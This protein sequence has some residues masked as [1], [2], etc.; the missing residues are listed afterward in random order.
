MTVT[1]ADGVLQFSGPDRWLATAPGGG[2]RTGPVAYNVSVPEGFDRTDLETYIAERR[3]RAG[4]ERAGPA[5]LTGVALEHA[6]TARLDP[7]TVVATAGLSNPAALPMEPDSDASDEEGGAA[8]ADRETGTVNLLV[9]TTR[10][11]D[12]GAQATLLATAVEAKTAT[13]Q[14]VTGF[15]GTTS[16]AVVV[17]STT[18]GEPADFAGSGTPVGAATRACVREAV[19]AS[20]HS[21]YADREVPDSVADADHGVRTAERATVVEPTD[22]E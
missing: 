6:R 8:S 2:Y 13:L 22:R 18:D 17:G 16:D 19:R 1:V 7:V 10:A 12:R 15:T 20:L 9:G 5:L 14:S 4:F 21:R 11:L 3:E